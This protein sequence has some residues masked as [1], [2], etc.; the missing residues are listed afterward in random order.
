MP[1]LLI[2]GAGI[3][4]L[5]HAVA[6]VRRGWRVTVVERHP[7]P[8]GAS[9][10]NFG[11]VWPIGQALGPDRQRALRSRAIWEAVS[12][13]AGFSLEPCGSLVLAYHDDARSVL[14][15]FTDLAQGDD[16]F[17]LLPARAIASL[18]P[19]VRRAGLQAGL[20]SRAEARVDPVATGQALIRWLTAQGVTFYFDRPAISV[21][22]DAIAISDGARLGFD[23][24]VICSG[25]ELSLLYPDLLTASCGDVTHLQMLRT[26]PM[27]AGW[28]LAPALAA[29]LT[30][31]HYASFAGCPSLP[32]LRE[33]LHRELPAHV[34][35]GIHVLAVQSSDGS[36]VLGDSH[37]PD[38]G[39]PPSYRSEIESHILTYLNGFLNTHGLT[40]THRWLGSYVK[41]PVGST[42]VRLAPS[43]HIQI[44]TG[45]G[46][47]GMTISFALAEETL[48]GQSW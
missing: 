42:H 21:F 17:E 20:F 10:R 15:E 14:Q 40:V 5:A 39:I 7:A 18:H 27:P 29:E 22:P 30:M 44:V 32:A 26:E 47:A 9:T 37:T 34:A 41:A 48:D 16:S 31:P 46:G 36:L 33:R 43:E 8:Q 45:L 1:H 2:I 28:R 6:G 24:L 25:D 11:M 13:E 12:T 35:L 23:R 19:A 3:V 4:G 38:T